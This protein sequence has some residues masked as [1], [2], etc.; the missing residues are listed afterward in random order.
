[1]SH[2]GGEETRNIFHAKGI[3]AVSTVKTCRRHAGLSDL[4]KR[5]FVPKWFKI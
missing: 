1:M 4:K 5:L 2:L 3:G